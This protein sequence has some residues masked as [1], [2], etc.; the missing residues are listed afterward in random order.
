MVDKN[1]VQAVKGADTLHGPQLALLAMEPGRQEGT[2]CQHGSGGSGFD[3]HA[4]HLREVVLCSPADESPLQLHRAVVASEIS[5][6]HQQIHSST[7]CQNVC[8]KW[9]LIVV[10]SKGVRLLCDACSWSGH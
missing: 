6:E 4:S 9:H 10:L 3:A 5:A 7:S 1:L 2:W 8:S